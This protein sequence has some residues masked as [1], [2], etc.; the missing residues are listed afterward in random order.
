MMSDD[1][2]DEFVMTFKERSSLDIWRAQIDHLVALHSNPSPTYSTTSG[3]S[4]SPRSR[5]M[6]TSKS[7]DSVAGS[8]YSGAS[9]GT[10]LSG[11]S[12]YTRT[13]SSTA[14][15][16]SSVI[17]EEEASD[18]SRGHGKYNSGPESPYGLPSPASRYTPNLFGPRDF[19]PLD[20]MLIL[21]VP[22]SSGPN[23]LKLGII[24]SSL[25]FILQN[26]GPRTRIS[27]VTF[28]SGEGPRGVLRKTP[29]IALGKAEGR[30][31]L[32]AVVG[33]LGAEQGDCSSLIEHKEER[34]N[35][36]TACNL[37]L[38]IVLQRKV[39]PWTGRRCITRL[40]I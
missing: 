22:P 39:S 6:A 12:G 38:D 31:R 18:Y 24:K 17:H 5:A 40:R 28:A 9:S 37:A 33:E 4:T 10:H 11:F 36:V 32:E 23:S 3:P 27:I 1:A 21:S 29:F 7:N 25:D 8:D 34:V 30:K 20:L 2:L 16:S 13:T 26:V 15:L 35:L 14:P 19:T